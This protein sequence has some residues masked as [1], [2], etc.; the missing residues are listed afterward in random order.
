MLIAFTH[1]LQLSDHEE[2]AEFDRPETVHA[3]SEALQKFGHTVELIEVSGPASR[4]VAR[5]EALNPHI[6]F[7]TAEG[8]SGRY[9]EAFYPGLFD[10]L[11]LAYTGSDAYV[12]TLTLD[13]GLAS[14]HLTISDFPS[15]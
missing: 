7:N 6:V 1:N 9:R 4:V 12:C 2:E 10:Q 14:S 15:S 5:L 13:K 8:K 3:I 11:G